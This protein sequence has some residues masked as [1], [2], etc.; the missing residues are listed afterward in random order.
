MISLWIKQTNMLY[1][2]YLEI[3]DFANK[4]NEIF[5]SLLKRKK[6]KEALTLKVLVMKIFLTMT[7]HVN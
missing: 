2:I 1:F 7:K 5:G 4:R 3:L 6:L